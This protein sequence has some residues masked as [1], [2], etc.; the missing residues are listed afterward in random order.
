MQVSSLDSCQNRFLW[1]HKGVDLAS[2]PLVGFVPQ[3]GDAAKFP[4]AL[5]LENLNP[6]L[7]VSLQGQCLAVI[8]EGGSNERPVK[9]E[10]ACKADGVALPDPVECAMAP[11]LR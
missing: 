9:L 8:E 6:F 5:G 3:V 7:R 2:H 1:A 4:P 11:L 10:L